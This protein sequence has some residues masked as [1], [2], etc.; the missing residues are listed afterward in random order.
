LCLTYRLSLHLAFVVAM[1]W[2]TPRAVAV[3]PEQLR[4][5]ADCGSRLKAAIALV[6]IAA[7]KN[8]PLLMMGGF[9]R[10]FLQVPSS[11]S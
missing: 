1:P 2:V 9:Q 10:R 3:T 11:T 7:N 6:V 8:S 5:C 4:A